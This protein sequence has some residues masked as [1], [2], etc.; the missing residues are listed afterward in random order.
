MGRGALKVTF[1]A[2][3]CEQLSVSLLASLAERA[4]HE[5]SLAFSS[6][7][8]DDRFFLHLPRLARLFDDRALVLDTIVAGRPQVLAC[9]AVTN[10]YRWMLEL[11]RD[12][13]ARLPG[14][15][16]VFGGVHPSAVPEVVLGEDVVD[17]VCVGEGDVAFPALL[18][19]IADGGPRAPIPNVRFRAPD[20]TVVRGPQAPFVQ[21]L[22]SL[23]G[24]DKHLWEDHVRIGDFYITMAGRGCPYRCS[25]CFNS[26]FADLPDGQ[27]GRYVRRR[28]VGHLLAE[29]AL[30]KRRYRIRFVDFEDDCFTLD[31]AWLREF[32]ARYRREIDVP[33]ACLTHSRYV[34]EEVARW[35]KEAGCAWVQM[36]LQS[37]DD[38]YKRRMLRRREGTDEIARAFDALLGAG[39]K[40]KADHIFGLPGEPLAA[41][42]AAR[43]FFAAHTPARIDTFWA[44]FFPGTEMLGQARRLGLVSDAEARC[45][46]AGDLR[47]YH[48]DGSLAPGAAEAYRAYELLFRLLPLLPSPVRGRVPARWFRP[49][50]GTAAYLAGFAADILN[51]VFQQSFDHY[52][53]GFHYAQSLA[54]R[55][56]RAVGLTPPPA[57]RRYQ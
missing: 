29:L 52:A 12:A 36:G 16:V 22:D 47:P 9:S 51:G 54:R 38:D 28:S 24:Y 31:R 55:A 30:A 20:G 11:A 27:R 35:H 3:G 48:N 32:L 17:F 15:R 33:F 23:P 57:T 39:I 50:P 10:T 25:F 42:E 6:A 14:L 21:D 43:R 18:Q 45:I 8:F 2:I 37:A 49:L 5:T 19:A 34:D 13:K 53:Y 40:L 56:I 1:V 4:G 26:F 41:Q 46:D 7:L 44:T